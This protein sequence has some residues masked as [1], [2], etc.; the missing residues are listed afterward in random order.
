MPSGPAEVLFNAELKWLVWK[1]YPEL[2]IYISHILFN[3][4]SENDVGGLM[5][6]IMQIMPEVFILGCIYEDR[7]P[8]TYPYIIRWA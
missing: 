4:G 7:M 6:V 3:E 2:L 1:F 8:E 5:D